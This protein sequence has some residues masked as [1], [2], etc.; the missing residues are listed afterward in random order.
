L[1]PFVHAKGAVSHLERSWNHSLFVILV[2]DRQLFSVFADLECDKGG[3]I[4]VAVLASGIYEVKLALMTSST[5]G[6]DVSP[7]DHTQSAYSSKQDT[8]VASDG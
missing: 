3:N 1:Q 2:S 5:V 4:Q 7:L 6:R 8:S